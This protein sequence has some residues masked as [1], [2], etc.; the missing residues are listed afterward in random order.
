MLGVPVT[1]NEEQPL[2]LNTEAFL[3]NKAGSEAG[4][5]AMDLIIIVYWPLKQGFLYD[6]AKLAE[7]INHVAPGRKY[8]VAQLER[9]K[10]K[11]AT[12]FTV[13]EDG[14]WVPSP[15]YFSLTDGNIDQLVPQ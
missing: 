6:P 2:Y 4:G 5:L 13:L 15:I 1:E 14:R 9:L 12:F 11:V 10:T 7:K 8:D 3:A